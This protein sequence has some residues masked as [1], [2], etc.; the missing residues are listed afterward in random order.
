MGRLIELGH[1]KNF[2]AV[3]EHKSITKAASLVRLAQ[4]A[5]SRQLHALEAD[6]GASLLYRH[7]WGITPTPEGEI[8]AKHARSLLDQAQAVRDAVG[9]VSGSPSGKIAIGV[10]SSMAAILLPEVALTARRTMPR[11][12]LRLIDGY[13][14]NLQQ[15]LLAGE[16]DIAILYAERRNSTLVTRPLLKEALVA[17]GPPG[18]F[19]ADATISIPELIARNPIMPTA[20]NQLRSLLQDAAA[21]SGMTENVTMAVDS[22]PALLELVFAGAGLSVLPYSTV[23]AS[24]E[25]GRLSYARI[26]PQNLERHLVLARPA[27]RIETPLWNAMTELLYGI[28]RARQETYQ[29]T[30]EKGT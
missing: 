18:E 9:A 12:Q 14:A 2:L 29:W 23:H 7:G 3:I 28:L 19:G 27:E 1:L 10:P 5:L 21:E 20:P 25:Q 6:L 13:T 17:I 11:V 30:V 16:L 22:V 15:R 8:L 26:A 4:P 24:V